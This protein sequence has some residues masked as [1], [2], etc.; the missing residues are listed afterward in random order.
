[1]I[2]SQ[3][4]QGLNRSVLT[5]KALQGIADDDTKRQSQL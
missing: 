1:M 3:E 2:A 4:Y 5:F